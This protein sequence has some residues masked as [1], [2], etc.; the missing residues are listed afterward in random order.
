MVEPISAPES[1]GLPCR[2]TGRIFIHMTVPPVSRVLL[3]VMAYAVR[4]A[5]AERGLV[6]EHNQATVTPRLPN[7]GERLHRGL[8][9][10]HTSSSQSAV[11]SAGACSWTRPSYLL[12]GPSVIF[13][14]MLIGA[15]IFLVLRAMGEILLSNLR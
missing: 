14:Y 7:R 4:G 13:V 9:N 3:Q 15:V 1:R 10:R 11:P 5:T 12:A 8:S 6:T 2:A